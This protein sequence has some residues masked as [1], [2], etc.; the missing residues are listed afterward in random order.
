MS[1][2][3]RLTSLFTIL[4]ATILLL[5]ATIVYYSAHENREKEFYTLLE[6]EAIT[7]ANLFLNANV[8]SKTLQA[9]Y[10]NNRTTLNEVETAIYSEKLEL[11]YHD[12][13]EIDFVKETETMLKNILHNR[14]VQFYQQDWQVIGLRYTFQNKH[15][16]I[17]AAAFDEYGYKKLQNLLQN[18]VIVFA[19]SMLLIFIAGR[20]FA[21][22]AFQPVQEMTEKA[23]QISATNLH[24]RLRVGKNPDELS[25]LAN[26]FN[27]MLERLEKSF[28]AQKHFVSNIAHELRTPL[29]AII[30]E[31]ELALQR[32]YN[33]AEYQSIIQNT[34]RDAKKLARLSSSLL[35]LAKASY[36]VSEI[37][38]KPVRIDE[39]L[40][41]ACQE[42]Q[43][44]NNNYRINIHFVQ[45][46][47]DEHQISVLGNEY[48]LKVA[49]V[50]LME[51]ACKFS[52]N[53]LCEVEITSQPQ[54]LVL[55]FKDTGTGIDTEDLE[56]IFTPFFRGKNKQFAYGNGI[57]LSLTHK[58]ITL[59]KGN[60][61]VQSAL[62]VGT[63]FQITLPHMA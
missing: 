43:K 11:L 22:R 12:A 44:A 16:L 18:M 31:L 59:H 50:N 24:L 35:D 14:K 4:T 37:T 48:L 55:T 41:D 3:N 47:E 58:I 57:G 7:K 46:F 45:T 39:I 8:A 27:Q 2:R 29:A 21:N 23:Q 26:T 61:T 60:I 34:L 62:N 28:E 52:T 54:N 5:F 53:Q 30:T 42:V 13:V 9:I 49:F 19:L 36:D 40:L 20:Y 56:H 1:V 10:K 25:A 15:Y 51:N 6:K 33:I 17:T 63:T 38:L 32:E